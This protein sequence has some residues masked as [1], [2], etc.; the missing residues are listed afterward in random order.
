MTALICGNTAVFKPPRVTRRSV[1]RDWWKSLNKQDCPRALSKHGHRLRRRR[2][3][4]HREASRLSKAI[5]F[6]GHKDTGVSILKEAGLKRVGLELGGKNGIIVMDDADLRI[7]S[8][9]RGLGGLG[10]TGQR[11][12][13]ASRVIV[14]QKVRPKFEA[15]LVT[16]LEN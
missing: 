10:T 14:H 1:R 13:A 12:T 15:M 6:T 2:W 4:E 9:R 7:S 8:G 11:C 16:G 5:S 3:N